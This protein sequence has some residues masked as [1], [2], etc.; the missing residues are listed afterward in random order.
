M[1]F[2]Y[3]ETRQPCAFENVADKDEV[4]ERSKRGNVCSSI[5]E[6]Y[7]NEPFIQVECA[8]EDLETIISVI[9]M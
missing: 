8:Y 4:L 1:Q 9:V 7:A 5:E 6:S 2:R 3:L